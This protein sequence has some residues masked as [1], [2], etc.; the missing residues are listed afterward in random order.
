MI[1]FIRETHHFKFTT[2]LECS[3]AVLSVSIISSSWSG[4]EGLIFGAQPGQ[5]VLLTSNSDEGHQRQ[6]RGSRIHVWAPGMC[7]HSSSCLAPQLYSNMGADG[8]G[9]RTGSAE[10]KATLS[11]DDLSIPQF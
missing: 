8:A 6:P 7:F 11:L 10:D 4:W 5:A 9:Y 3:S 1:I 2:F